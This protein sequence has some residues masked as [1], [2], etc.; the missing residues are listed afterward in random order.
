M[1]AT[2]YLTNLR[3][4]I[5]FRGSG[6]ATH[7]RD[8]STPH[9]AGDCRE[10]CVFIQGG[11]MAFSKEELSSNDWQATSVALGY[12]PLSARWYIVQ[13]RL[14]RCGCCLNGEVRSQR[15]V[16]YYYWCLIYLRCCATVPKSIVIC[17]LLNG[18]HCC[19]PIVYSPSKTD[20][21]SCCT[22]SV[23]A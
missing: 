3:E 17:G 16:L 14:N 2:V 19:C 4:R 15:F 10:K 5:L 18:V 13:V 1:L 12:Y 6:T 7:R 11:T 9:L 20:V 22:I 21:L 23:A 8:P